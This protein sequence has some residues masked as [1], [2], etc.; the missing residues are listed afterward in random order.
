MFF[1]SYVK[2]F[3]N[4]SRA[5]CMEYRKVSHTPAGFSFASVKEKI[6]MKTYVASVGFLE[7]F[8]KMAC[9]KYQNK[10]KSGFYF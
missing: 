1:S 10:S 2:D 8:F 6:K 9:E 4:V 5:P 7:A 3:K